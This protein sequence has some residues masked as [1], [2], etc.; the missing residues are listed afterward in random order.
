LFNDFN[1]QAA[2]QSC[3]SS[4][5][6]TTTIHMDG[7]LLAANDPLKQMIDTKVQELQTQAFNLVKSE[8]FDWQP[9]P[10]APVSAHR[11][12]IGS[13]FGGAA[14]VSLKANYQRRSSSHTW[15]FR[16]DTTTAI[17]DT[18]SGT[19]AVVDIG[20]YFKKLQVAATNSVN[21]SER[22]P[23]GTDLRDPIV[24]AQVEIAY[25]DY[26]HPLGPDNKPNP[27]YRGSGFH[28]TVA[29][30]DPNKAAALAQWTADN[31]RDIINIDF[32]KLD[33]TVPGW[34]A[35]QVMVRKT[36]V[37][38]PDDPR[39]ELS[40]NQSIVVR[41][42]VTKDHAPVITP[43]EVGYVFVKFMLDRMLPK[44]NITVT[45]TCTIG[46]RTDTLTITRANQKNIMWEIFSDKYMNETEF[47]YTTQVE[48][49]GPDFTDPPVQYQSPGPIEV[50]LPAG[51]IK[52]INPLKIVLPAPASAAD[53]ERANA[54]IKAYEN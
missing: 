27:Q 9:T 35:D 37:Y 5:A 13:V 14:S 47:T 20:E 12:L 45:L 6:I 46:R 30:K 39:V 34:P 44:D 54:Y 36:I 42:S 10:D 48:I 7:A 1:L 24:S 25:L 11:G 40:S 26:S 43:D 38:N 3:I 15:K 16:I 50:S 53:A 41:E 2:Y 4:S 52:Y 22:L 51:R 28:Y 23:D 32:L 29:Q 21:W 19:L 8:I 18:V 33:Q 17:M 31:P 49:V